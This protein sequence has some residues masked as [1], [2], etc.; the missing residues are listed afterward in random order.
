[1]S[2]SRVRVANGMGKGMGVANATAAVVVANSQSAVAITDWAQFLEESSEIP[3][4][5]VFN[6]MEQGEEA[7][8]EI[9]NL[10][11]WKTS[12]V[13]GHRLLLAGVSPVFRKEFFGPLKTTRD[14]IDIKETTIEAFTIMMDFIYKHDGLK[15]ISCPQT[16]CQVLNLSERYQVT[17]LNE[18]VAK[19]LHGLAITPQNLM[20]TA[21]VA[22]NYMV[23]E[24]VS[25]MLTNKC[26]D[27][28]STQ[29]K[30]SA[31]V[32]DFLQ[33]T[34][35]SFPGAEMDILVQL[36]RSNTVCPNCKKRVN[37]CMDGEDVT[38]ENSATL[39]AGDMVSWKNP[40]EGEMCGFGCPVVLES[41][42][43]IVQVTQSHQF[44]YV[45][46]VFKCVGHEMSVSKVCLIIFLVQAV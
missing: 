30:T 44:G 19:A 38:Q 12:K 36:L 2:F 6:V 40:P 11:D 4:D 18:S 35:A 13:P 24:E 20:F 9:V 23:F 1:M 15:N 25:K 45:Q 14:V 16:L 46:K 29:F 41:T 37:Q 22:K 34:Y 27:F 26:G 8:D 3:P 32:F 39:S 10:D 31:Q 28:L 33:S 5:I 17:G 7:E 21:T 43:G 42:Y